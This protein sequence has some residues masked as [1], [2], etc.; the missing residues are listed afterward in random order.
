MGF[1]PKKKVQNER[2]SKR[3]EVATMPEESIQDDTRIP[4]SSSQWPGFLANR[5]NKRKLI[6]YIGKKI[7]SLKESLDEGK[8]I[9]LGGYGPTNTTFKV[10]KGCV[11][12]IPQL[13][14]NHEEADT[15]IFA[16]AYFTSHSTIRIVAA[17][18]DVFAILL[19]NFHHF[20]NKNIFLDQGDMAKVT[21]MNKLVEAMQA[22]KDQDLMVLKQRGH[23]S[24][25]FFF[26]LVHPLIGSDILCSPR[27][28][29]PAW[30]LKTCIDLNEYIFDPEKG[31]QK[32]VEEQPQLEGYTRYILSLYKKKFSNKIKQTA[33]EMFVDSVSTQNALEQVRQDTWVY[34]LE[35]NTVLPS[36]ECL[37]QRGLNLAYQLKIWTQATKP[38]INVPDPLRHGWQ[39]G[40]NGYQ[41]VPDSQENMARQAQLFDTVMKKCRCKKSQCKNGRC[42]CYASKAKCST[43]CEC[44]NCCNPFADDAQRPPEES[45]SDQESDNEEEEEDHEKETSDDE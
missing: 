26:G 18:T 7:L 20:Q 44:L 27:S 31:I 12:E 6:H 11:S 38:Q 45:E 34:T 40:E 19:L 35:N 8:V 23:L 15:Q 17:D 4:C 2:D 29:G 13:V 36:Q 41:L 5:E 1:Q 37:N 10:E 14:C 30:I 21:D 28:F 9:I 16:H 24:L 22:D 25:P 42:T 3:K 32:L 39:A 33:R 43:F